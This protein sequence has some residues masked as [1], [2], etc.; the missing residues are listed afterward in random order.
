MFI[1]WWI[2]L[3]DG[4]L[5]NTRGSEATLLPTWPLWW[6]FHVGIQF[7]FYKLLHL[8]PKIHS[9][10]H[11]HFPRSAECQDAP[12]PMVNTMLHA[13]RCACISLMNRD[14]K[15]LQRLSKTFSCMFECVL[16]IRVALVLQICWLLTSEHMHCLWTHNIYIL[17]ALLLQ[18]TF[19]SGVYHRHV[20]F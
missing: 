4:K 2:P 10:A 20:A 13:P 11:K 5:P 1:N 18:L 3:I 6:C 8:L 7:P 15:Q 9:S 17:F 16:E 12:D 19:L 14:V